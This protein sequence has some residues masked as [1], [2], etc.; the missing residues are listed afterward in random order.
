[1]QHSS[2]SEYK[3]IRESAAVMP[4]DNHLDN[5][6]PPDQLLPQIPAI[7][8][9]DVEKAAAP[10]ATKSSSTINNQLNME[11]QPA[12]LV[13]PQA[14]APKSEGIAPSCGCGGNSKSSCSCGGKATTPAPILVYA[15]GSLNY[16]F[17][18]IS[19]R[20]SINQSMGYDTSA[21]PPRKLNPDNPED[22]LIYLKR[23]PSSAADL[24]W[25]VN[26]N[27]TPIYALVPQGAYAAACY[28]EIVSFFDNQTNPLLP[29]GGKLPPVM[30]SSF[31]GISGGG[32]VTLQS[33][34]KVPVLVP[35]IRGMYNWELGSLITTAI[36]ALSI[37]PTEEDVFRSAM[38]NFLEKLYFELRNMGVTSG[39]RA[40]N[41][42]GTN[43]LQAAT[44]LK[45]TIQAG[46]TLSNISVEPSPICSPGLDC[47]DVVLTFFDPTNRDLA[48]QVYRFT[49][50]VSDIVPVTMGQIEHWPQF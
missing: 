48:T 23:D 26:I 44:I 46:L 38:I 32:S 6:S 5:Q 9:V 11:N 20:D 42:A 2:N 17:G 33:G 18:S 45:D 41:Y 16:D 39:E 8:Q 22:M 43:V 29:L 7:P 25:T 36:T 35:K 31:P 24:I 37:P 10:T 15:L 14:L 50:D 28:T 47:Q 1:M 4:A 49:V 3:E 34:L 19:H 40:L 12:T 21:T 13:E 30:R 27:A